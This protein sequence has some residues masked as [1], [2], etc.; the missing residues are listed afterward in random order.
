M[1]ET[2]PAGE[3]SSDY[4]GDI[5]NIPA[6]ELHRLYV[7]ES[8][9]QAEIGELFDTTRDKV[10]NQLVVNGVFRPKQLKMSKA[11]LKKLYHERD[12]SQKEIAERKSISTSS[13]YRHINHF[14][15]KKKRSQWLAES[16]K[17]TVP[18]RT[19]TRGYEVWSMPG[20]AGQYSVHRL[21]AIAEYGI[22]AVKN[23]HVHHKNSIKWDNRPKNIELKSPTEHGHE[24]SKYQKLSRWIEDVD[25]NVIKTALKRAGYKEAAKEI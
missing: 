21:L 1:S 4:N 25:D 10:R 20:S 5:K 7:K 18:Y 3:A 22:D 17:Y 12:M 14:D 9:T 11:E 19:N 6:G 15:L 13:V 16:D 8:L 23:K 24:H 2:S